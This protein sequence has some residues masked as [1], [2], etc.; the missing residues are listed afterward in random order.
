MAEHIQHLD[1]L[2][3]ASAYFAFLMMMVLQ[4]PFYGARAHPAQNFGA[5]GAIIL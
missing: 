4:P 1:W 3:K 5:I 2:D